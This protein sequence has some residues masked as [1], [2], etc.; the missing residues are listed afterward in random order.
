MNDHADAVADEDNIYVLVDQRGSRRI[1][2]RQTY[3]RRTA[4]SLGDITYGFASNLSLCRQVELL[5]NL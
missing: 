4:L 1:I 5:L 2:R 3:K